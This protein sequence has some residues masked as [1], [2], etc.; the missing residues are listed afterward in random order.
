ML[1]KKI[2]NGTKAIAEVPNTIIGKGII[3]EA[4][5]L[6][7]K[8]S[9]R[10]DGTLY[11]DIDIEGSLILGES[12]LIEGNVHANYII[13][14]GTLRGDISCESVLHLASTANVFGNIKTKTIIV[15]EGGKL[16][17]R[18]QVGEEST[19]VPPLL[20]QISEGDAK[21]KSTRSYLDKS[22]EII[23]LN[24]SKSGSK[25]NE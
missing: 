13:I 10:I 11:G 21:N 24:E 1:R 23:D 16:D 19:S 12:A 8:E 25:S 9:L 22:I 7:G 20:T 4:S 2:E 17:G 14:A 18:Y 5:R 15:D 3:I 6:T